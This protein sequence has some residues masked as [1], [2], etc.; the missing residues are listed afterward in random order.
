MSVFFDIAKVAAVACA[1]LVMGTPNGTSQS[2]LLP[3]PAAAQD[4]PV[5]TGPAAE[6]RAFDAAKATGT[7]EGWNGFLAQFPG[8]FYASVARAEIRK[9]NARQ[10]GPASGESAGS[11]LTPARSV[12][13]GD[14]P[15]LQ[16]PVSEAAATLKFVNASDGLRV[17]FWID[18]AGD[19]K[20]YARVAPGGELAQQT[21][22]D[23]VWLVQTELGH[24]VGVFLA[25]KGTT[26]ANIGAPDPGDR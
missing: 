26:V 13:C 8:G 11:A 2:T 24:C 9:L 10:T 20:E 18:Y 25:G 22:Q 1:A 12:P 14:V 7:V 21:F 19:R 17:V 15:S 3:P 6:Q 4:A 5:S 16:S 23:H